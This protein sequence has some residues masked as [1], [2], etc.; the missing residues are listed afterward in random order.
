MNRVIIIIN[1]LYDCQL[2]FMFKINII[3]KNQNFVSSNT[4]QCVFNDKYT[5]YYDL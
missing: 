2:K 4:E 5:Y 1:E 3:R